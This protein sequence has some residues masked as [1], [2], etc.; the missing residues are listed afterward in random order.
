MYEISFDIESKIFIIVIVG[1]WL[2]VIIVIF[3]VEVFV[4]GIWVCIYYGCFVVFVDLC[5]VVV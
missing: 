4:W 5:R 1:F 3:C 2:M